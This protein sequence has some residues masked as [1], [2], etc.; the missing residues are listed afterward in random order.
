[1]R[2]KLGH[3]ALGVAGMALLRRWLEAEP[4][5]AD[6]RVAE[7]ADLLEQVRN[8]ER[9]ALQWFD[10]DEG[11]ADW[12][13]TYDSPGNPLLA[14]EEPAVRTILGDVP[15]GRAVDA[16]CGT[17]RLT[18]LLVE[19][20]HEVVGVDRSQEMLDQ[21][22]CTVADVDLRLGDL[23]A[24]PVDDDDADLAV[25]GLA[26]THCEDLVPIVAELARVVRP[27]GRIVTSDMHPLV[28]ALGGHA[29][30][31]WSQGGM[32][33]VRNRHHLHGDY[34]V[35]FRAAGLEVRAC[36]EPLVGEGWLRLMPRLDRIPDTARAGLGGLPG[37][38]IW[39]L[40]VP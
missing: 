29:L 13:A 21:A 4:D 19:T 7:L 37:V 34:L 23:R 2:I 27:G 30:F 20:G 22:R 9:V 33:V 6:S 24:L 38:L 8:E 5:E 28:V 18:K 36:V 3:Y 40:R 17:G 1:M 16:A 31:P 26:L 39:D 14:V 15:A 12:A 10:S 32:G 11:Y 35:A 25:C